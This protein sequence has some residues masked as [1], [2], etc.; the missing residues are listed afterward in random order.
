MRLKPLARTG[1]SIP[2]IGLGTWQYHSGP[3]PLRRGLAAGALFIDTAESYGTEEV[4]GQAIRGMR[5]RVFLATKVSP[6]HFRAP[7]FR[8]ALEASL[9]RLGVDCVDLLQLHFPNP[10]IPIEETMSAM[11]G[12]ID[13]G[14]VRFCGVSNFSVEQMREA[15]AALGKHPIVSNQVRYSLINRT[16]EK[17][18]LPYCRA[19]QITVIAYSPLAKRLSRVLDCDPEGILAEI[20]R[21]TGKMPAQIALNWCLCQDG[22]VTI[23]KGNSEAHILENCGASDW[24]LSGEHLQWLDAK[25][26]FRHRNRMDEWVRRM[27]PGALTQLALRMVNA[28]PAG[29]RRRVL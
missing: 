13:E 3:E 15:Q 25:I 26:R 5:D 28:L 29:L 18:I 9:L 27:M 17:D 7:D 20:G 22:V 14:K 11:A 8:S 6:E 16:I 4:V 12:L 19:Q 23:P 21:Q 2:E 1:V 24:R 10:E